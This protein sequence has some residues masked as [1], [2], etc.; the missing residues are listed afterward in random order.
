MLAI[1]TGQRQGELSRLSWSAYEGTMIRLRQSKTGA[2]VVIPGRRTPQGD[3]R[4]YGHEKS[5]RACEQRGA[6]VDLQWRPRVLAQSRRRGQV[7]WRDI[8]PLHDL[9][10]TAVT[11]LALAGC[12]DAEIA[13]LTGHSLKDV[14]SILDA[15]YLNC[16]PALAESA[17]GKL[18]SRT[19]TPN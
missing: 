17:V 13:T 8:A 3:A 9:R 15:H 19:K 18:E 7:G 14:H 6:A 12:T 11:R 2:R 16:D 10:G 1:W 4:R 5:A